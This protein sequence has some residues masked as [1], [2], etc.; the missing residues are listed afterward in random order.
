MEDFQK[1]EKEKLEELFLQK[2]CLKEYIECL[3]QNHITLEVLREVKA[4]QIPM[5]CNTVK[6]LVGHQIM[7]ENIISSLQNPTS[8]IVQN[9][10]IEGFKDQLGTIYKIGNFLCYIDF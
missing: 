7:F 2:E 6:M 8:V 1:I 9:S 3:I 4:H 5:I 10:T